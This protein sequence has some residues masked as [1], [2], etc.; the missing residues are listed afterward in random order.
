VPHGRLSN[1]GD[2]PAPP[3]SLIDEYL[4]RCDF[5]RMIL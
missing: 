2:S 5:V 3:L 4:S 1:A